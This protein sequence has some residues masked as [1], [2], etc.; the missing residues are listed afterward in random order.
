MPIV[1]CQVFPSS[2][3][4]QRPPD[5]I[6]ALNAA[7]R[8]RRQGRPARDATSKPGRCS[9]TP[10]GDAPLAEFPDLLHPNQ[11]GYAEMGGRAAARPRHARVPA[12]TSRTT[13]T[14]EPGFTSLFNGRDLTG[15]GYRPMSEEDVAAAKRWMARRSDDRRLAD[16]DRRR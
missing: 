9:P 16:R 3:A 1:L 15:W 10:Q 4:K 8:R 13:F 11:A 5:A 14:P 7:L 12:R 2:P 6:K